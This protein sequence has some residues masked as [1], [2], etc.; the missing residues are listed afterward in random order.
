MVYIIRRSS[1]A[2]S[3]QRLAG[4]YTSWD[5]YMANKGYIMFTVNRHEA[6]M[7]FDF[8]C[9]FPPVGESKKGRD[10]VNSEKP[11]LHGNRIG[12]HSWK[13]GGHMTTALLLRYPDI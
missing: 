13:L 1:R 3:H 5:I 8:K 7:D 11:P 9:L 10:Q 4:R 2:T 12:V 6:A